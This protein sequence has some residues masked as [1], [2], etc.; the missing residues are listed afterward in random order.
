MTTKLRFALFSC[1]LSCIGTITLPAQNWVVKTP[2]NASVDFYGVHFTSD[3]TGYAVGTGGAIYKTT[4][5]GLTWSSQTSSTTEVLH[6]VFFVNTNVGYAVGANSTIRKTINGGGSW[7]TQT[8]PSPGITFTEIHFPDP[9]TPGTGY[10]VGSGGTILKTTNGGTNWN[11]QTSG[12][13]SELQGVWFTSLSTGYAVGNGGILL[14]TVNGGTNWNPQTSG[15]IQNLN[16]IH[17]ADANTGYAVGVNGEIRKTVN[18]GTNW[19]TAGN[20]FSLELYCVHFTDTSNGYAG[21]FF[22][23][24]QT[25][26]GGTNWIDHNI[27][28][29]TAFRGIHFPSATTGYMVGGSG[30]L[31]KY[32]SQ[33]EPEYQ[34]TALQFTEVYSTSMRVSYT[35]SVDLPTG[36]IAIRKV[37]SAPTGQPMDGI[38]YTVGGSLG[39]GSVEYIGNATSF[40]QAGL[41]PNTEYYYK[42]FAYNG[43][44]A[45]IN[46]KPDGPL[47]GSRFTYTTGAPWTEISNPFYTPSDAHFIDS[48]NGGASGTFF[49]ETTPDGGQNW[50]NGFPGNGDAYSGIFFVSPT[51]AY[52]VGSNSSL[53]VIRRTVN[54]GA[55]WVDQMRAVST[56]SL[57]D[58]WFT[59]SITGFA[60]GDG[61]NI[62][63]TT[64]GTS[65]SPITTPTTNSLYAIHFPSA[66]VGYAVGQGGHIVRTTD[67]GSNWSL[68]T[69]PTTNDLKGVWFVNASTGFAA[70]AGGTII[71]TT[72]GINWA[73]QTSGTVTDLNDVCFVDASTGYVVGMAGKILKTINAGADWYDFPTETSSDNDLYGVHFPTEYTGYAVGSRIFKFQAAPEPTSQPSSLTFSGIQPQSGTLFYT[74]AGGNVTGYLILRKAG[75]APVSTPL[76]G[77]AYAEDEVIGDATV[78]YSGPNLSFDDT[79]LSNSTNYHYRIYS[80]NSSVD[81]GTFNYFLIGPLAG[82]FFTLAPKPSGQPAGLVFDNIAA[83]SLTLSFTAAAGPPD[84]YIVLRKAGS[85]PSTN[86]ADGTAYS[87]GQSLGDATVAYSG[88]GVSFTDTGL[89]SGTTY[90]YKVFS[91]NG[92]GASR[93]Y[94]TAGP[95]TGNLDFGVPAITSFTPA[96]GAV[97]TN[98][99]INGTNF[100]ASPSGNVVYFGDTRAS[101]SAA[102]TTQLTVAVPVGASFE[103]ISV[104][105]GTSG[106]TARSALPFVVTFPSSNVGI[107]PSHYTTDN[108]GFPTEGSPKELAAAD[109]DGDGKSDLIAVAVG[110][111]TVSIYRNTGTS[112][113]PASFADPRTDLTTGGNTP[114]GLA[115][116]DLDGDGKQD[117]VITNVL[118]NTVTA[119]R[120][121]SSPGSISFAPKLDLPAGGLPYAAALGDL[122]LDG[123]LDIAVANYNDNTVSAYRNQSTPGVLL[124]A[125]RVNFTTGSLPDHVAIGDIDGDGKNDLAV[126]NNTGGSVSLFR[127]TTVGSITFAARV[128]FTTGANTEAV[129]LADLDN[130]GKLDMIAAVSGTNSVSVFRNTATAGTINSGSFGAKVDLASGTGPTFLTVGDL[131]G[132]GK[133]DIATANAHVL[134][135]SISALRNNSTP[136]VLSF[137]PKADIETGTQPFAIALGDF[138]GDGKADLATTSESGDL[139]TIHRNLTA[140]PAITSFTPQSGPVGTE[141]TVFG[142]GFSSVA[143]NNTVFFGGVRATVTG[144]TPTSLTVT[145]PAGASF[146]PITATVNG[147]TAYSAAPFVTTFTGSLTIDAASFSPQVNFS[148]GSAPYSVG[149]GDID[150]DG[151]NDLVVSNSSDNSISVF[152]NTS[153]AGNVTY[154][155]RVNFTT[156]TLPVAVAIG[157]LDGDGKLDIVSANSS[158]STASVFR[159]TSTSGT[160]SLAAH[161]EL[162]TATSPQGVSIRD[163]DGDGRPEIVMPAALSNKVSVFRNISSPG[164]LTLASFQPK[165]DL[166]TGSTPT[167]IALGDMTAD[168]KPDIIV[169]NSAANTIS[170]LRNLSIPNTLSFDA[171]VDFPTGGSSQPNAVAVGDL[172][173]DFLPDLAVANNNSAK[174]AVFRNTTSSGTVS[175]ATKVDLTAGTGPYWIAIGDLD[176]DGLPDLLTANV[177]GGSLS[178]LRNTTSAGSISF[179]AKYDI[180]GVG[181]QPRCSVIAD[182][183]GDGKPELQVV[184][185]GTNQ[186]AAIRNTNTLPAPVAGAAT[187]VT[188]S[189]F[190]AGWSAVSY[191]A[192]YRFDVSSDNFATFVS[193][194]NNLVVAGTSQVVTGLA[195]GTTYQYRVRSYN[196]TGTSVNSNIPSALTLPATP[197]AS[198][199]SAI[200]QTGFTANWASAAG[201]TS[202]KLD[203]SLAND[204]STLLAGYDNLNVVGTSAAVT[205][206]A[207]GTTFYY[208][209]RGANATGSTANSSVI[210]VLTLPPNPVAGSATAIL[211]NGFT[212][213]WTAA[214]SASS[215]QLDI[216]TNNFSTFIPGYNGAVVTGTSSVVTGLTAGTTYQYRL[217]ALNP[218]GASSNSNAI[219]TI[220]LSAAPAASAATGITATGFTANWAASTGA[221]E[222]NLDVTVSANNFTPNVVGFDNLTVAGTS[223]SVTGLSPGTTYKFRVRATNAS[224]ASANSNIIT[225]TTVPPGPSGSP[226]TSITTTGFTANWSATSGAVDYRLD[227]T[228]DD[229][230]TLVAGYNNLVVAGLSSS[231]TGLSPGTT[232]QYRIRAVNAAGTSVNSAAVTAVTLPVAPTANA[233]TAITPTTFTASWS[234]VTGASDYRI[235]V[236][237]SST[238]LSFTGSYNNLT[239]PGTSLAISGLVPG[240]TYYYRVRASNSS[241]PSAHSNVITTLAKP[242]APNATPATAVTTTGFTANWDAVAGSSG[243]RLDVSLNDF[244]SN[245]TGYSDL[246]VAGTSQAVAGLVAGTSY[247]YRVRSVNASGASD[248]SNIIVAI[249]VPPAPVATAASSVSTTGFTAN[250]NTLLGVTAYYLDVSADNFSTFLPGYNNFA[251]SASSQAIT[252][253][254]A[255]A[256]YKYR[257]RAGNASGTSVNSNSIDVATLPAA[258]VAS[259]ATGIGSAGFTAN[260]AAATG[261]TTYALDVSSDPGFTSP[262][263]STTSGTSVSVGGLLSGTTYYYRVRAGNT[264]GTSGNSNVITALT[265]PSA[266]SANE[267]GSVTSTSFTA[268]WGPVTS[269][270]GYRLDVSTSLSFSTFLPGYN[271]L[272]VAGTSESIT[273]LSA[274][275]TYYYRVRAIN[276]S[277]ASTSSATITILLKPSPPTSAAATSITQ[278]SFTANWS[279]VAGVTGYY[280]DVSQ[281][282]FASFLPGYENYPLAANSEPVTGLTP[283]GSYQYRVRSYNATGSSVNSAT[284]TLV[285][286]PAAPISIAASAFTTTSFTANWL[287]SPGATSYRLDVSSDLNFAAGNFVT[288]YEDVAVASLSAM[289]SGLTPGTVYYY[290]V[291]AVNVTGT[292]PNSNVTSSTNIPAAPLGLTATL[293]TT[294]GFSAGWNSSASAAGYYIDVSTDNFSTFVSGFE[295][296]FVTATSVAVNGL[297]PG[298][299]YQFRLRATNASGTSPNSAAVTLQTLPDEPSSQPTLM[300]F[301]SITPN[302][303]N[304]SFSASGAAGYLV[305]RKAGSAPTGVP[306]DGATYSTGSALG[307]GVVVLFGSGTSFAETTLSAGV[308]YHYAV[309]AYNGSGVTT[310]YAANLP[311]QASQIT[312]P[313][314]PVLTAAALTSQTGFTANWTAVTGAADYA[315]DVSAD[316]FITFVSG[317]S[318][319]AT[320]NVT[321]FA[322][323]G[324]S[325]GSRYTFRVRAVNSA[326]SSANSSDQVALTIPDTP[327]GLVSSLITATSFKADWGAVPGADNYFIDLSADNFVTLPVNNVSVTDPNFTFT[328]LAS[329]TSYKVRVRSANASGSS[330]NSEALAV[331]TLSAGGGPG[332]LKVETPV[333][334]STMKA[335]PVALSVEVSGGTDPKTATLH[336]RKLTAS[337]FSTQPAVLRSGSTTIF[338][339][340][341]TPDMADELGVEFYFS[342]SDAAS[343]TDESDIH[344]FIYQSIDVSSNQVIPFAGNAFNGKSSTYQ[345]FSVPY[346][347]ADKD[348]ADLF[349]PALNGYSNTR[350]RLFHFVPDAAEGKLTEYPDELKR[351]DLGLGYWFNTTEKDFQIKLGDAQVQNVT[352]ASVFTLTLQPGWNQIGD[353]YPFNID[354]GAVQAANP[355]A[356]LNSL[357]LFENGSYLRKS[358][359]AVWKGAF[360]FSD[361]GGIV[362]FPL[363]AKTSEAGRNDSGP[364]LNAPA[365]EWLL[366]MTIEAGG[367]RSSLGAG[368]HTEAKPGKDAYDE[369]AVPRLFD[370][371]EMST[372]HPEFFAPR[373]ATDVVPPSGEHTWEYTLA[374]NIDAGR[375]VITW[376]VSHITDLAASILLLDVAHQVIVNMKTVGRY[377][378]EM[379]RGQQ[380]KVIL[381]DGEFHPGLTELGNAYPNPFDREV[382]FPVFAEEENTS[383]TVQ[384]YNALG[385]NIRTLQATY[386]G[387]GLHELMWD[388]L[389]GSSDNT[390]SG[391]LLYQVITNGRAT[392]TRRL[393]KN[394]KP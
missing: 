248:N 207:A 18:G 89:T 13:S 100:S 291:R 213:N 156:G 164:T 16:D 30:T 226:A 366:P 146:G 201:A 229:F 302:S 212:A 159:N 306:V 390:A 255:G 99:T 364:V 203:V 120:N 238:F 80:Y 181:V 344:Y 10:I 358:V 140:G 103:P 142:R 157:D 48:N 242:A 336:Y 333:F 170:V 132:D 24:R 267:A 150:G 127:N 257:V 177:S 136:G 76:D 87:A 195:P 155:A 272:S 219:S 303:M 67:G 77:V 4:D 319:R 14:Y 171:K 186:V 206:L 115:V 51:T 237:T 199:A 178:A 93:N 347:L 75:S 288:G 335:A 357:W 78:A 193:G 118:A 259:A 22:Y 312:V 393:I 176:G 119:F 352:P 190:T 92:N 129:A 116:G 221:T 251:T 60:C 198:A 3:Q 294:T 386:E 263:T 122:N 362:S 236:S 240:T 17:F 321:S 191:A 12:T 208:R 279:T 318:N 316:D 153:T 105:L 85:A 1:L 351:I 108:L 11:L 341:I 253:L 113:S 394:H 192:D 56:Y 391:L 324:L 128:D 241:G 36:Y 121:T 202:Y 280:L 223:Q 244:V 91:Y 70:G 256:S 381:R 383:V 359:L 389:S 331:T 64:N 325:G 276:T 38:T 380:F 305:V 266:P 370:Y 151:K 8:S 275:T 158:A 123:K 346:V 68:L 232:Y 185:G 79:G 270:T 53:R 152:R 392:P 154:A 43:S 262:T 273:G 39:D 214:Q 27:P 329:S 160:I 258:P 337:S 268:S 217:R 35:G 143:A 293:I 134:A 233:S 124:F 349:D 169:T 339:S 125:A 334:A 308:V 330:P 374:T 322:V 41:T 141:V 63:R 354:W 304:V 9:G 224:G 45:A 271:D 356:G 21:S 126:A 168:G 313:D 106:L 301:S 86:P 149:A 74:A 315:L 73:P 5:G 220:T 300:V 133:P 162:T 194:Y 72:D 184:S 314:A 180:A 50:L 211:V 144:A 368:M 247:K 327:T 71:S 26:D 378:F 179:A 205:G 189:G 385:Q 148:T 145:A 66:S 227:V 174:V 59:N 290:R 261:A 216:S 31:V 52:T 69:S 175:F 167:G 200:L 62:L 90:F 367:I 297:V 287:P 281:N 345:M 81:P 15:T 61:G 130:N 298:T 114:Q 348:I 285:T 269:A 384:I 295:N 264:S 182:A 104:T 355:G 282:N 246:S 6:A 172:N 235:D 249:T 228:A 252:G 107:D 25:P 97:G 98:V 307:D 274:G 28:A 365:G 234:A 360:V 47:A 165:L 340:T 265:L 296:L 94:L 260:W 363:T 166:S 317:Y 277:G 250:W 388:G 292:S 102:S 254:T 20:G 196:S 350:W 283:G 173:G 34:A 197:V 338:E 289:V 209:V 222:Y 96:S 2:I 299:S 40:S 19:T 311:L 44:G 353:P 7:T 95:L 375:A 320:G 23:T 328:A 183:D 84:G 243:Y 187:S 188:P 138:D 278:V 117:L 239:V 33:P 49:L 332:P 379:A 82:D 147:L 343:T 110:N 101:V 46:Y 65:W 286:I 55:T 112:G 369:I 382:T 42:I 387:I 326:G 88:S 373:F 139:V 342:A 231:V 361:N 161:F 245:V 284:V 135:N 372:F 204:F 309:F 230:T 137:A 54:G 131:D 210:T 83:N 109:I 323:T 376:D 111:S 225:V 163:L 377:E 29:V 58:V 37:G 218:S 310:N 215:Y 57:H 371:L 32:Q